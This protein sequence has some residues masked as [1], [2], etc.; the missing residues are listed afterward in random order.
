MRIQRQRENYKPG[1]CGLH[2]VSVCC[3]LLCC[4]PGLIPA[5]SGLVPASPGKSKQYERSASA[6]SS[7]GRGTPPA[8]P[9]V[10]G[11]IAPSKAVPQLRETE[12]EDEIVALE[13]EAT[14]V[15]S[16]L[17]EGIQS[18]FQS[19]VSSCTLSIYAFFHVNALCAACN[20]I[21]QPL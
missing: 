10:R 20:I 16:A 19:L 18:D 5:S 2:L 7:P 9:S 21:L 12:E 8:S 1:T 15:L 17:L 11:K 4:C 6:L 14:N 3:S 13:P